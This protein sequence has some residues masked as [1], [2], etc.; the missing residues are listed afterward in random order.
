MD[1]WSLVSSFL[2]MRDVF[3]LFSTNKEM[4]EYGNLVIGHR[5][6]ARGYSRVDLIRTY[7]AFKYYIHRFRIRKRRRRP[8][9]LF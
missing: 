4:L 9:L 5:F 8:I 7:V 2:Q 6:K 1:H 3:I